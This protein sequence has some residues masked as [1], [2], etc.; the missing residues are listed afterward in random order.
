MQASCAHQ[1]LALLPS[2]QNW[3]PR[4]LHKIG[5]LRIALEA[6]AHCSNEGN[7][8]SARVRQASTRGT[9]RGESSRMESQRASD[10]PIEEELQL[11]LARAAVALRVACNFNAKQTLGEFPQPLVHQSP[12]PNPLV[13]LTRYGM[14][15][16]LPRACATRIVALVSQGATPPRSAHRER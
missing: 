10:R 8:C 9:G 5:H 1:R 7:F 13:E 3:H 14:A 11:Q 2:N 12:M 4:E 6:S 16:C 15:P